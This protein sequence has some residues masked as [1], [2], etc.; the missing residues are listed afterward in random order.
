LRDDPSAPAPA[1][2]TTNPVAASRQILWATYGADTP[3]LRFDLIAHRDVAAT[4]V[5]V[6]LDG[7][8]LLPLARAY[9]I[10]VGTV[11]HARRTYYFGL[12]VMP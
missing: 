7:D 6:G 11:Q 1:P 9:A 5:A 12:R 3:G 8:V 2:A 10:D 4:G